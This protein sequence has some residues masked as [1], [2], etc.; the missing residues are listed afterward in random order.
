MSL[1][2]AIAEGKLPRLKHLDILHISNA[3]ISDL[4]THSAQWNHLTT[5][6]IS[7]KNVVNIEPEFLT[8]LEELIIR[9]IT[10]RSITRR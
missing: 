1:A 9:G 5:L 7:D 10:D 2:E 4:F 3:D 6:E 8:S